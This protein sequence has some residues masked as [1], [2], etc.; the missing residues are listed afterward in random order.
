MSRHQDATVWILCAQKARGNSSHN[1]Y[2]HLQRLGVNCYRVTAGTNPRYSP[3]RVQVIL[4][5]G[6]SRTPIW[7]ERLPDTVRWFNRPATVTAS[8]NKSMMQDLLGE[9]GLDHTDNKFEAE[10]W[11]EDGETVVSRTILNGS[12]GRGIVLSPPDPLPEAEL[13]TKLF[14]APPGGSVREYRVYI[15]GC[16]AIDITEKRRWNRQRREEAGI[17]GRD[18]YTRLIRAH[19]NGWCFARITTQATDEQKEYIKLIA[20]D[21]A[22]N[23]QLGLGGV[24]MIVT[25]NSEGGIYGIRVVETN[26]QVGINGDDT[27]ASIFAAAI[28]EE[29]VA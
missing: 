3:H 21:A 7:A 5:W 12:C 11:L 23:L 22:G 25:Y 14:K 17:D 9:L 1:L 2:K 13:Y 26:T 28:K 4:N 27:T 6:V 24:D 20:E 29:L 15:V 19:R 10:H 18:P 16:C 8:S